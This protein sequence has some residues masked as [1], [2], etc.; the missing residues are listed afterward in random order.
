MDV[1]HGLYVEKYEKDKCK[2]KDVRWQGNND[3]KDKLAGQKEKGTTPSCR[4]SE[5][6][7]IS[8]CLQ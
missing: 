2:A 4:R 8:L 7:G 1:K 5:R 6:E 3:D